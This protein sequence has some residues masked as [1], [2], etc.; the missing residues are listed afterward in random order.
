MYL[1]VAL[2]LLM[3]GT[4]WIP[5]TGGFEPSFLC[6]LFDWSEVRPPGLVIGSLSLVVSQVL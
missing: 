4:Q 1:G 6:Y 5:L 3:L 2:L